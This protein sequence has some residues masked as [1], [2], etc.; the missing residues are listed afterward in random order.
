[1]KR[2]ILLTSIV[3]LCSIWAVAQ[4]DNDHHDRDRDR[5][6]VTVEG[7]LSGADGNFTLTNQSGTSY[8][9]TGDTARL[10]G[11]VGHTIRVTGFSN[12]GGEPGSMSG[13]AESQGTLSVLSFKHISARCRDMGEHHDHDQDMGEHH[14]HDRD[15]HN[16]GY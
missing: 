10:S 6:K 3:L 2:N 8:Q 12:M 13:E 16:S 9:L 15:E 14:D 4:Y 7:C 11:H 5:S 1:M